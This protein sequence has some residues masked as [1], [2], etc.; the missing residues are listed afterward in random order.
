M[1]ASNVNMY[2]IHN[3]FSKISNGPQYLATNFGKLPNLSELL[4]AFNLKKTCSPTLKYL[5][6]LFISVDYYSC[7]RH[8]REHRLSE[9]ALLMITTA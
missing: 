5:K 3:I 2:A 4:F 1:D 6:T 7:V 9:S 8:P